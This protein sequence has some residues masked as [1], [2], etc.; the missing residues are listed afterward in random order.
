MEQVLLFRNVA[1]T[2][3]YTNLYPVLQE[4][5]TFDRCNRSEICDRLGLSPGQSSRIFHDGKL[6]K[7]WDSQLKLLSMGRQW[8]REIQL[9]GR[10]SA[11]SLRQAALNVPLFGLVWQ[12]IPGE[13]NS[14]RIFAQF[15]TLTNARKQDL[16]SACKR[17]LEALFDE[18]SPRARAEVLHA[19]SQ[20][21]EQLATEDVPV[22]LPRA[23][24][25]V[26]KYLQLMREF[27]PEE[28]N[29]CHA[30]VYQVREK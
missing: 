7:L 21:A 3:L 17:Y 15:S 16:Q 4:Y 20:I 29:A 13:K 8:Q 22:A 25:L 23:A 28:V 24:R 26:A 18:E 30:F 11:E 9:H 14:E 5:K 6:L 10:P 12:A 19:P 2:T 1:I 27:G